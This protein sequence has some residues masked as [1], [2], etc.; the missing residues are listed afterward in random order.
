M[1]EH[2]L[3]EEVLNRI[4]KEIRPVLMSK[5]EQVWPKYECQCTGCQHR[6]LSETK[7][8]LG[9]IEEVQTEKPKCMI[10]GTPLPVDPNDWLYGIPACSPECYDEGNTRGY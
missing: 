9:L 7:M 5:L 10:C 1:R 4:F 3:T 6:R 2:K 8:I